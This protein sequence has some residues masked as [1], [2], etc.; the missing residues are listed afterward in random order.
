METIHMIC[1][2]G[3]S[4]GESWE[5]LRYM[6]YR[7][8]TGNSAPG[9]LIRMRNSPLYLGTSQKWLCTSSVTLSAILA[10]LNWVKCIVGPL[11][12]IKEQPALL[13]FFK[14]TSIVNSSPYS[15]VTGT[16]GSNWAPGKVLWYMANCLN[17][18]GWTRWSEPALENCNA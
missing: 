17:I 11:T 8:E 1:T 12:V 14:E 4:D 2:T 13:I 15:Y 6:L 5:L 7:D 10:D 9:L 16:Q 18:V 3:A